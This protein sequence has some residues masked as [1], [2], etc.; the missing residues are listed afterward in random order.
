MLLLGLQLQLWL[1]LVLVLVLLLVLVLQLVE[2]Q[3]HRLP[4]VVEKVILL[5]HV[6]HFGV[7]A[8]GDTVLPEGSIVGDSEC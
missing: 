6:V 1:L 7:V 2:V 8:Y 5:L 3:R 4:G